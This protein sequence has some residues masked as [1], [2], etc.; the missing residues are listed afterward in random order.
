[1]DTVFFPFEN[2]EFIQPV[3]EALW[4]DRFQLLVLFGM[5]SI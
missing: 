2:K 4:E 3:Q 5:I 1:M